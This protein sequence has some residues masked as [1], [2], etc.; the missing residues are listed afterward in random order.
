MGADPLLVGHI[1]WIDVLIVV[2]KVVVAFAAMMVSVLLAI[3]VERKVISDMQNRIGPNRAGPFGLLQSLADGIKLFFKEDLIPERSDRFIFKLAPYLSLVPAFLT[4]TIVPIGGVV[5]LFGHRTELQVADPPIGILLL[6]AMSSI[7]VYGVMLA[8]WSSGS[9]YPLIGSVRAS[10]QMISY[11][12]AMGLSIAAVVLV[13]GSLSTRDMVTGQLGTYLGFIPHWNLIRLGVIPFVI[14]IVAITAEVNRPPFDLVEAEQELVG[15][16]HTEYS[17]IRFALFYLAEYL[18]TIT[19][20]AIMVTLFF[21]GPDGP[22]PHVLHWLW[23]IVWFLVKTSIFFVIYVW[24][25][26]A[27]PRLRY[28]QLMDLGWKV[29]IPVSLLWLLV[30]AGMRASRVL[31]FVLLVLGLIA[32]GVLLRAIDV[33]R[34]RRGQ[35]APVLP[36]LMDASMLGPS[37][38]PA[39]VEEGSTTAE[40]GDDDGRA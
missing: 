13:T 32:A 23:P 12:A 18:N 22:D 4:F 14:F 24:F 1:G 19:M 31:G 16:F 33:G 38:I 28:D 36:D 37:P 10:A 21:G 5:D 6:L 8:G 30:V 25:R 34:R 7:S 26:A 17:S 40:E 39:M 35:S 27:L 15:G 11:E 3:W 2:I 9:K 20:S 29:L